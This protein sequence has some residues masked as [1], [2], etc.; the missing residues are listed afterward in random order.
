MNLALRS[1]LHYQ[2]FDTEFVFFDLAADRYFLL[3]GNAA[4]CFDGFLRERANPSD[5]EFLR[6]R[7]ILDEGPQS[8]GHAFVK[9]ARATAS[10][11]DTPVADAR[12][13]TTIGALWAQRRARRDLRHRRLADILFEMRGRS[14]GPPSR[15]GEIS[16]NVAAAFVRA[17]RYSPAIDQCLVR[18]I[19]MKRML[20]RQG[21]SASLV[22][23]VT[24]PFAAHCWVQADETVLTD[25]LDII[26]HY[27]PIFAV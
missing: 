3:S 17:R 26:L 2:Q 22:F 15:G 24:M 23:G 6:S 1:G 19:A 16:G 8:S 9:P 5:R 12:A 4:G 21:C 7:A 20:T 11:V 10:L 13:S 25:P 18:G 14:S 27:Q